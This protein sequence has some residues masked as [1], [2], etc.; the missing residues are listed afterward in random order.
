MVDVAVGCLTDSQRFFFF[1]GR[2][3][4]TPVLKKNVCFE[5][6]CLISS[7]SQHRWDVAAICL[8]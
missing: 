7:L 5:K 2:L 3:L 4:T 1:F 8:R 6:A